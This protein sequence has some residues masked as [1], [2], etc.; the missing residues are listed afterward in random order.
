[1]NYSDQL[2]D[3]IENHDF[4]K[5]QELLNKALDHDQPEILASLAD[6]LTDIG[7]SDLAKQVYRYLIAQFPSEDL[8]KVYLAEILLNDGNDDDGLSL[9]YN[10]NPDSDAYVE[11][12]LTQAD[13]Y[14][15]NGL[16][17]TAKN[18]L[19]QALKLAPQEDA[20]KFGLAELDYLSGDYRAALA[21]YQDLIVRQKT[22]GEVNLYERL[23]ATLAKLGDYEQ[24]KKIIK[25]HESALLDIDSQYQAGL[26]LY[27]VKDYTGAI[28]F[29]K[30]VLEQSPDYVNAYT[31]LAQAYQQNDDPENALD[32]AQTGLLYNQYDETLY[33]IGA[34]EATKIDRLD[35][36][37]ELLVKGLNINPDNANLRLQLSNLY[38]HEHQYQK[39]IDLFKDID[40]DNLEPQDHWN[41]GISYQG[42]EKYDKARSE[43]LLAY[44]SFKNDHEFIHQMIELFQTIGENDTLKELVKHYLQLVP[45]DYQM[46]DLL[47]QLEEK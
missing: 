25:D 33:S 15:T 3:A 47:E 28:K 8:F 32:I 21:L 45:D 30:Q 22:F 11:S 29:L 36:A 2:L 35:T 19:T 26:I 42:L 31:V 20:I 27:A 14:Q 41:L 1:M 16:I 17:E 10:I 13:Y 7:F 38:L 24:A 6:N 9:L 44:P 4:S 34:L 12:L 43:Y 23:L 39:N 40:D 18:K 46:Q 37:R 5:N